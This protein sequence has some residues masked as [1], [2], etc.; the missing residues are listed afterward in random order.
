VGGTRLSCHDRALRLL[1]VRPRSR[2][3]LETR[4]LRAGF[5][6]GE[7]ARELE[8]LQEVGLVDDARFAGGFA[9]Q[10]VTRRLQGS[11]AV[12]S[13]LAAKG[14]DRRT[15]ERA[16]AEVGGDDA[17]R[18]R[19]VAASRVGRLASLPRETAYRRLVSFLV[20]RGYDPAA[21]RGA[22]AA[23]LDAPSDE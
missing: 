1:S 11:R 15:I 18:I 12:A 19:R 8:R 16:L 3:E 9:E 13:A 10:A 6:P 17:E 2:R 4:L 23:A 20:R 14:V 22:A 7:V 21:A 5:E